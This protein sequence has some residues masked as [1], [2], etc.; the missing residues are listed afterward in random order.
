M[1]NNE[2]LWARIVSAIT[3]FL[4]GLRLSGALMGTKDEDAFKIRC[5]RT[6][7]TQDDIDNGR[8]IVIIWLALT[9]PA[10]F[11]ILRVAHSGGSAAMEELGAM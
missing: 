8:L 5:D 1:P 10:E 2:R 9:K 11:V 7:M 6:T 3:P 4:T